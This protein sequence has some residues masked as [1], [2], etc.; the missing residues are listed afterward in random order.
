MTRTIWLTS[1]PKSGN[2]WMRMLLAN[3]FAAGEGPIDINKIPTYA[4]ASDRRNFDYIVMID[5]GLLTH[6]EIDWLR[7]RAYAAGA[8]LF[9][10]RSE[11]DS[12]HSDPPLVRFLKAHDAYT[13][14][15]AGKPLLGGAQGADGAIV[16]VRDPRDVAPS[17]A[18]YRAISVDEAIDEMNDENATWGSRTNRQHKQLRQKLCSW[19]G[20]IASWLDQKDVPIH[21]LR[22][23]DMLR[24]TAGTL[25]QVLAFAGIPAVQ[26]AIGQAV[27]FSDFAELRRQEQEKGFSEGPVRQDAKFFRRGETGCWRDE[28]TAE[29]VARIESRHGRMMQR[30]G[31][32]LSHL[33]D[34]ARAG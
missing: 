17:L 19:S 24:D 30:L 32:E 20:H 1:Y 2:T 31:Y 8:A 12:D 4:M 3:V 13:M 33:S 27:A 22:Y 21:L 15:P 7:P 26:T 34:I 29:Q 16:I 5:S 9:R 18:S 14:N 10:D 28:L 6:D 25:S 11:D 23:E